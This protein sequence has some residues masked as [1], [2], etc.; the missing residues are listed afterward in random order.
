MAQSDSGYLG[1]FI[2]AKCIDIGLARAHTSPT[3]EYRAKQDVLNKQYKKRRGDTPFIGISIV[4][5]FTKS[6]T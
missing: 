4:V 1:Y 6:I 2:T 3:E 5:P